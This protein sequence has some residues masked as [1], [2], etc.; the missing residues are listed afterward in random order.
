MKDNKGFT[1]IEI[2]VSFSLTMVVLLVIFQLVVMLKNVYTNE[3]VK[4]ELL[5]KQGLIV[6]NIDR[7]FSTKVLKSVTTCSTGDGCYVFTFVDDS[8]SKLTY[9]KSTKILNFGG[10]TTKLINGSSFGDL[11]IT[12]K[13]DTTVDSNL[14]NAVLSINLPITN[15]QV[16]G[17]YGIHVNKIYNSTNTLVPVEI[18]EE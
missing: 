3:G 17:D 16:K 11:K 1:V 18:N 7:E 10:Y 13:T 8:V 15:T 6:Q 5:I 14:N 2:I 12:K 4:T 9:D